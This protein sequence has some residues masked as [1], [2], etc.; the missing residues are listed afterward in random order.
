LGQIIE[1][2]I[3]LNAIFLDSCEIDISFLEHLLSEIFNFHFHL[4]TLKPFRKINTRN[5]TRRFDIPSKIINFLLY[6]WKNVQV[7]CE[8][9]RYNKK[10]FFI[11][12]NYFRFWFFGFFSSK[13]NFFYY[14]TWHDVYGFSN[15]SFNRLKA[16]TNSR[17]WSFCGGH[18]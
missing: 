5:L 13:S 2:F 18:A 9:N 4:K 16:G 14:W 12:L 10:V 15:I 7:N 6:I 3:L 8:E 1:S 11:S 17:T